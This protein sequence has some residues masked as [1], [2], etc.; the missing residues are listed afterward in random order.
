MYKNINLKDLRKINNQS[1]IWLC[2]W[3]CTWWC[4][5]W[6]GGWLKWK[7]TFNKLRK[8]WVGN[9]C[10]YYENI[11]YIACLPTKPCWKCWNKFYAQILGHF[12]YVVWVKSADF[13][14]FSKLCCSPAP[15]LPPNTWKDN[16]ACH[17][18]NM[19][20]QIKTEK[21]VCLLFF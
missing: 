14:L 8:L 17:L 10:L 15:H 18:Q 1:S 12:T 13:L 20:A 7:V 5:L 4:A 16:K 2:R 21:K 19:P 9:H 11:Y 6:V 3:C